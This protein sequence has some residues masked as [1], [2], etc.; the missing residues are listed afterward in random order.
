MNLKE[1][2]SRKVWKEKNCSKKKKK[3]EKFERKFLIS[4]TSL[5]KYTKNKHNFLTTN[6][7]FFN[8]KK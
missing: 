2:F 6:K 3:K 4:H 7:T 8:F 5:L 1:L